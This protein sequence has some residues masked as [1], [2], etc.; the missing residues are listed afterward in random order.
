MQMSDKYAITYGHDEIGIR[1]AKCLNPGLCTCEVDISSTPKC[2]YTAEEAKR[3]II[4]YY[5]RRVQYLEQ[6]SIEDFLH[7]SGFYQ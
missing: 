1:A 2:G 3:Y 5:K 4:E 7:D 6:Q